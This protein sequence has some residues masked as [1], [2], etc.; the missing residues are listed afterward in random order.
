M[1][2]IGRGNYKGEYNFKRRKEGVCDDIGN[3]SSSRK[4]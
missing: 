2:N 1:T 4:E 3:P